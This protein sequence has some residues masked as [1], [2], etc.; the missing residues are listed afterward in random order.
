[1]DVVRR[2]KKENKRREKYVM[3][4]IIDELVFFNIRKKY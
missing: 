2:R 4:F 1:V 3:V